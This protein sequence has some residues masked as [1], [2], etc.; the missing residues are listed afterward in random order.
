MN[1]YLLL[2]RKQNIME[3][4][5]R[6]VLVDKVRVRCEKNT[7]NEIIETCGHCKRKVC[8]EHYYGKHEACSYC[9]ALNYIVE[10]GC[11]HD[12]NDWIE[13]SRPWDGGY[14][15]IACT[16]CTASSYTPHNKTALELRRFMIYY[17]LH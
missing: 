3:Q 6:Y 17:I 16:K 5:E 12:P 11:V 2:Y 10:L 13:R 7:S 9:L 15:T 8:Y 14:F 1:K 4:C